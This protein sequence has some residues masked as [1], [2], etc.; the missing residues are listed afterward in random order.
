MKKYSVGVDY[1]TLSARAVLV[2]LSNGRDVAVSEFVYPHAVIEGNFFDGKA[3]EPDTALQHPDDYLQALSYVVKGVLEKSSVSATDVVGIGFDFTACTALPVDNEGIPLCFKDKYKNE[4]HAYA[5]LWK[6]HAAQKQADE[7]TALAKKLDCKWLNTYGGKV[8]SEWLFPKLLEIYHKAPDVYAD[9]ARFTEAGDWLVWQITGKE[10]H[11]SCMAGYKGLWDKN[12]G[13]PDNSFW[14]QIDPGFGDIIGT[15]ISEKVIPTGT[16][17]GSLNAFGAQITGLCEGTAVASPIIDAHAAL[18]AAGIVDD[19]KLMIIVGTSSCHI[20]LSK[21][22]KTVNGICGSVA[23]GIV[24]GYVAYEAGQACVG[25]SF[26]WFIKNCVPEKYH[27]LAREQ[28]MGIF[29]LLNQKASKIPAGQSGIVALDWWNGNR[30]PYADSDLSGMIVGLNL[31]TKPENIYRGILESTAFGTKTIVELY[32]NAGITIDEIYAAGGISQKNPF[33][34]QMYADIIGKRITVSASTQAGAKGS[35]IF[36]SVAG[37][38]FDS[39]AS[40][41][42]VLAEKCEK[43]YLPIAEN[44]LQYQKQYAVYKEL[45]EYFGEKTKIMKNIR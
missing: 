28:G 35:A 20:V 13:Y 11:N 40:A 26:E 15:R 19:G 38:Y 24:P 7:I 41:A 8:S 2:D 16:N 6:H 1:G 42:Q 29:D 22:G 5:K 12:N 37:G 45:S 3:L 32:E 43:T 14:A 9:T 25:D 27:I 21:N 33:L 31:S 44:T 36:A 39:V 17:A 30:T 34:M 18:P 4:P 23:D 10:T